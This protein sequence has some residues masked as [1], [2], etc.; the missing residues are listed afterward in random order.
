MI[1]QD[2]S[3]SVVKD[4]GARYGGPWFDLYS[5]FFDNFCVLFYPTVTALLE[6]LDPVILH[7]FVVFA[8]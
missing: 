6:Y 5:K 1:S 8:L 3:G 7:L 2:S 4:V